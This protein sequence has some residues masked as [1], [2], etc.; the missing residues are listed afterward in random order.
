MLTLICEIEQVGGSAEGSLYNDFQKF[1]QV[2]VFL[3]GRNLK[4]RLKGKTKGG[5]G[6]PI[7]RDEPRG[8]QRNK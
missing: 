5:G 4:G 7:R 2:S 3:F 1:S 8:R 6:I